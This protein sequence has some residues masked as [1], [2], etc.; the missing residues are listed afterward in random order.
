METFGAT[1]GEISGMANSSCR[2]GHY[3][4]LFH[5]VPV[6]AIRVAFVPAARGVGLRSR[7][8]RTARQRDTAFTLVR[9]P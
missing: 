6:C 5:T 8:R 7:A 9:D 3:G 4:G 2:V 1:E